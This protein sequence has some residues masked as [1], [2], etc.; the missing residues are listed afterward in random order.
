M[1]AFCP[2]KSSSGVTPRGRQLVPSVFALLAAYFISSPISIRGT[3]KGK[4]AIMLRTVFLMDRALLSAIGS[5]S[6]AAVMLIP[7]GKARSISSR[8][9]LIAGSRSNLMALI[10]MPR[11]LNLLIVCRTARF[12]G[13]ACFVLTGATTINCMGFA[14]LSN[15]PT[16]L[17]KIKSQLRS[18]FWCSG[19]TGV[20]R[21]FP[22]SRLTCPVVFPVSAAPG[23]PHMSSARR[24]SAAVTSLLRSVPSLTA[25]I[26]FCGLGNPSF[27]IIS[28]AFSALITSLFA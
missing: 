12:A 24:M 6:V 2:V 8:V 1:S 11:L 13:P 7:A 16:P 14:T 4:S 28:R 17:T 22:T 21:I 18:C 25:L 19:G 10:S 27:R 9:A 5:A 26:R 23:W 3:L 20:L 15:A